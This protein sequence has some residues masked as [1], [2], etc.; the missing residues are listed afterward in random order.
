M[1]RLK[2][3]CTIL[4]ILAC[5]SIM[6]VGFASWVTIN[7]SDITISGSIVVDNV[8]DSN[9]YITCNN[10]QV[11][12]Y[13]KTGFVSDDNKIV[14][15]GYISFDLV[16][17]NK[18]CKENFKD[19]QNLDISLQ[20]ESNNLNLFHSDIISMEVKKNNETRPHLFSNDN[21]ICVLPITI[22]NFHSDSDTITLH[23]EYVFT[24]LNTEK[25]S[26]EVYPILITDNF[27]FALS[28]KLTGSVGD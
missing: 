9:N 22:T 10:I 4:I 25:F 6:S 28:A 16:I 24:I 8:L 2:M 18:T 27:N 15:T 19:D 20:L 12:K 5:L 7:D 26:N 11:F 3:Q 14:N 17:N 23:I 1:R 13:F 21:N